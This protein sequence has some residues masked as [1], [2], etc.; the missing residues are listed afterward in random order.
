MLFL[1]FLSI[2]S[3]T[4][5]GNGK[6]TISTVLQKTFFYSSLKLFWVLQKKEFRTSLDKNDRELGPQIKMIILWE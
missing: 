5:D 2:A 3:E 4:A 6:I 1:S